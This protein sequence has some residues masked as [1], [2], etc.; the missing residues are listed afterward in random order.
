MND[1]YPDKTYYVEETHADLVRK[2]AVINFVIGL[3]NGETNQTPDVRTEPRAY[4]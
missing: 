1:L 4:L 3:I 2:D